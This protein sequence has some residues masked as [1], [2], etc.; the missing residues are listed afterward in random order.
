MHKYPK[1]YSSYNPFKLQA[2]KTFKGEWL[3]DPV[4][5][6]KNF[7][8]YGEMDIIG[9]TVDQKNRHIILSNAPHS[10]FSTTESKKFNAQNKL[11]G[12]F[13]L[14]IGFM[15][16]HYGHFLHDNLPIFEMLRQQLP[17]DVKFLIPNEHK[18]IQKLLL[19]IDPEWAHRI[20]LFN[21]RHSVSIFGDVYFANFAETKLPHTFRHLSDYRGD[22]RKALQKHEKATDQEHI[23]F[24]PRFGDNN[25]GR[26]NSPQQQKDIFSIIQQTCNSHNFNAKISVFKHEEHKTPELQKKFFETATII[27][28]VHGTALT[29]MIWSSRMSSFSAKPLQVIEGIGLTEAYLNYPDFQ[30]C[31]DLGYYRL[32][33]EGFNVDWRHFLYHP[34]NSNFKNLHIDILNI[35]R[36]LEDSIATLTQ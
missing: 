27:I 2:P 11:T 14:F 12:K 33:A 32:F 35:Q 6:C 10:N 24:C 22:L 30:K 7:N 34:S 23:I 9:D 19:L 13:C 21:S 15:P 4:F 29:N 28:G 8:G 3:K 17:K 20:E 1:L 18:L 25:N 31:N 5:H 16:N 26:S 36:A